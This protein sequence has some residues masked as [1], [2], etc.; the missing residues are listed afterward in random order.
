MDAEAAEFIAAIVGNDV[1]AVRRGLDED[2]QLVSL[3][4]LLHRLDTASLRR[5]PGLS[6]DRRAASRVRRRRARAGAGERDDAAALGGGGRPPRDR[7]LARRPRRG[8]RGARRVVRPDPA[9]LGDG[10]RLGAGLSRGPAGDRRLPGGGGR[11]AGHLL[12]GGAVGCRNRPRARGRRSRR[13]RA[14]AA[15]R[16]DG[17][18]AAPPRGGAGP[19][20]DGR[21]AA[22]PRRGL[23]RPHEPRPH[24]A[25]GRASRGTGGMLGER[26][27]GARATPTSPRRS[28]P[29][30]PR[31][32]SGGS[33]AELRRTSSAGSSS[34]RWSR[35]STP[36]RGCCWPPVRTRTGTCGTCSERCPRS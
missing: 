1:P 20:P 23:P 16:R 35:A 12:G 5:A 2:P 6:R 7:A 33:P 18:D 3:E 9:R 11:S 32:S 19:R 31:S 15:L 34:R 24:A 17:D 8:T 21:A 14:E 25:R 27:H 36:R 30:T 28:A 10:H 4:G 29:G 22:R 13:G 26:S